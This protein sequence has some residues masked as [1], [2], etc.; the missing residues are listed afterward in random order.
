M[1]LH[2]YK[3]KQINYI[4]PKLKPPIEILHH[5]ILREEKIQQALAG[6]RSGLYRSAR[7]ADK[8]TGLF[9]TVLSARLRGTR[10]RNQAHEDQQLFTHAE[11][12]ELVE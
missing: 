12:R 3:I 8:E 9:H 6:I 5:T 4:I 11:A 1:M 10:S 2:I 7:H